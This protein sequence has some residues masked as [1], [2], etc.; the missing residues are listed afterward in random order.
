MQTQTIEF[1]PERATPPSSS[2]VRQP[3]ASSTQERRCPV[4]DI[5]SWES[6]TTLLGRIGV[7]V[8]GLVAYLAFFGTILYA[9]GFVTN[10]V[11]PKSI[12]SGAGGPLVPALIFN[13][14]ILVLFVV[15][16]TIMARKWFK[17]W[18]TR[19]VPA[20]IERSLFVL[21]ASGILIALFVF[22][23]PLPQVVWQVTNPVGVWML[24]GVSLLGFAI[25]FYS[26]FIINH[27]DLFGLRQVL[28]AARGKAYEPLRFQL[29]SRY[30]LV[31]HPLMVGFLIAFWSTPLMTV[32]HLFFAVMTTG[33]IFFG[34]WVEERD[35]VR[36]F[37]DRY[38][39]YRRSVRGFVPLPRRVKGGA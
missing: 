6:A 18:V 17:A 21:A 32:G 20:S 26:S 16:H 3:P 19:Y 2:T 39:E 22:W 28:F 30:K 33:Y 7:L 13:G 5:F 29:R 37:G 24:T 4:H 27:F 11:V 35:L 15:Q 38:L 8:F 14:G 36:D 31:R 1:S 12:S 23:R 25:V 34:V 10:L 9:I